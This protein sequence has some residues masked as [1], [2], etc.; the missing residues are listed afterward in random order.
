VFGQALSRIASGKPGFPSHRVE[1]RQSCKKHGFRKK[2]F[3]YCLNQWDKLEV[4]MEDGRLEI[5]NN[6]GERSIK[7]V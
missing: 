5:S 7:H 6:H 4:F 2:Q 1:R 3:N